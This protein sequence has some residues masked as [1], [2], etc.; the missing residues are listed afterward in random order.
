M[1]VISDEKFVSLA[2]TL[3]YIPHF[4][5]SLPNNHTLTKMVQVCTNFFSLLLPVFVLIVSATLMVEAQQCRP[6]GRLLGKKPPKGQC[7]RGNNSDCCE[8][9]KHYATYK[10]SPPVSKATKA[11]LTI[12]SF[13]KNGDGG[14]PSECDG[15][16]HSD[17]TP[18]VALSTG[19]FSS[20]KRCNR[21][22][23][24]RGNGRSVKAKVVDE[25]DSTVGCDK[26]HDFQPPCPNNIVD[27]SEAVWNA[28]GVNKND[29][30]RGQMAVTWS[31][32]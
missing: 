10:C 23:I 30:R 28:L 7:N 3:L 11:T 25:C 14:S 5:H 27:A 21:E 31:D 29:G 20:K 8:N 16:F 17:R 18:V 12:N 22:I 19:W 15:K 1:L 4:M 26:A 6:S 32:A 13:Q 24:I 9:G 2:Q